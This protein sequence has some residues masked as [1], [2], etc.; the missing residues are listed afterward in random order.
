MTTAQALTKASGASTDRE[1]AA[2]RLMG[3][4]NIR[5]DTV[6]LTAASNSPAALQ[7]VAHVLPE[8]PTPDPRLIGPLRGLLASKAEPAVQ[9]AARAWRRTATSPWRCRRCSNS[10]AR[11]RPETAGL[12][13]AAARGL[14]PPPT[15]ARPACWSRCCGTPASRRWSA[16]PRPTAWSR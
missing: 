4:Q 3:R 11:T 10:S 8:D 14:R 16:P 13:A 1:E 12:R 6:V 15:R 7:A 2:R 5:A 9:D